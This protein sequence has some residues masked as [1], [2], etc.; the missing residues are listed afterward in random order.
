MGRRDSL[1][2]ALDS[3]SAPT[4]YVFGTM[5]VRSDVAHQFVEGVC[6]YIESAEMFAAEIDLDDFDSGLLVSATSLPVHLRLDNFL[7]EARYRRLRCIIRKTFDLELDQWKS[8]HPMLLMSAISETLL[9]NVHAQSLDQELWD[10]AKNL[11]RE[12]IGVESFQEQLELM[13]K[14]T[15]EDG[16]KQICSIGRNPARFRRNVSKLIDYYAEQDINKLYTASKRQLHGLRRKLLYNRNVLMVNRLETRM[17][18]LSVFA[19]VGAAHLAGEMGMLRLIKRK[20][21]RVRPI[22]IMT[23]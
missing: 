5:H 12:C 7:S 17:K 6:P 9:M 2:W 11:G 3:D 8:K 20:G 23:T 1:L 19:A 18:D 4:S 14:L 15:P 13:Q 16:I 22:K 10:R 21:Y